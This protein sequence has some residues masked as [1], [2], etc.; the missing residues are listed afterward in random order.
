MSTYD[1][2]AANQRQSD[3]YQGYEDARD[4]K[5][6]KANASEAYINGYVAGAGPSG[7]YQAACDLLVQFK[8][9]GYSAAEAAEI[10]EIALAGLRGEQ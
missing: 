9:D 1:I 4:G 8:E 3:F 7:L 2:S 5:P 10:M 6:G